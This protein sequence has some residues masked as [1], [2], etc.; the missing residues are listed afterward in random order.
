MRG[1]RVCPSSNKQRL[2]VRAKKD[3]VMETSEVMATM[4]GVHKRRTESSK[5][6]GK[7]IKRVETWNGF[8]IS[9]K[10]LKYFMMT[11]Q[12][13]SMLTVAESESE[14]LDGVGL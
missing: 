14:V 5:E 4:I 12:W 8:L 6:E 3:E 9:N 2:S 11:S 7:E 10:Q 13:D 1:D